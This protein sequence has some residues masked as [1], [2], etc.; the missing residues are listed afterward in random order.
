MRRYSSDRLSPNIDG[1]SSV[2]TSFASILGGIGEI[3]NWRRSNR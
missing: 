1:F 3:S 2:I